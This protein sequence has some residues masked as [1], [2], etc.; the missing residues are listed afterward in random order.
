MS[1]TLARINDALRV[2]RERIPISS[3]ATRGACFVTVGS[4]TSCAPNMNRRACEQAA[5]QVGG[6]A[7]FVPNEPCR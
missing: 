5:E 6:S 7:R 3:R 2:A 1:D 4:S